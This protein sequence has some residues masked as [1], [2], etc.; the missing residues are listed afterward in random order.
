MKQKPSNETLIQKRQTQKS[1]PK[2]SPQMHMPKHQYMNTAGKSQVRKL[3]PI[4]E[5]HECTNNAELNKK[6]ITQQLY[7]DH[8]DP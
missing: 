2:L 5:S 8:R 1:A 4:T 7:E 3:T 6:D